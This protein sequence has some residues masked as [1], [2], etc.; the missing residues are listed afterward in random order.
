MK[1]E[2]KGYTYGYHT[3]RGK[4]RTPNAQY[5]QDRLFDLGVNYIC[6]A[7]PIMQKTY[8]STEIL[9][10]YRRDVT[11]KD[12]RFVIERA[13]AKGIKVCLKPM[14]NCEDQVWRA[15]I[16]FPDEN[17]YGTDDYWK[18]WFDHYTA[19]M[20]HYAEFAQDM[21][22]EMLCIG[23]EMLGTERKETYWRELIRQVREVYHGPVT[24]N[25][26][27]GQEDQ[28]AWFDALDYIGTSAYYK[29]GK[30][31]LDS[32]ENMV[33][34]WEKVRTNLSLLSQKLEKKIIFMEIGCRSAE[35]CAMMP[36]DFMHRELPRSEEEQAR[37]YDSCMQVFG[38]E[39]WFAGVF[40]WDWSTEI[41]E[42]QEAADADRGFNIHRKQA[43][44]IL[45]GW[46]EK[47]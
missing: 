15:R 36:W 17:F 46:Y 24:Y 1:M 37:F 38:K 19:F 34:E 11:E 12:L 35:G 44:T 13:Q 43:E 23:C 3:V 25:T 41:Y 45:K 22:C 2:I 30:K 26:N 6:L 16:D 21:N 40:W 5:S 47:L 4:Y 18:E 9:F 33:A 14:I 8:S 29:V 27:H 7:F 31:P 28:V 42:T 39:E 20:L 32:T 10:D